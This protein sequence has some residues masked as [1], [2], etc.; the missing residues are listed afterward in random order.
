MP[1]VKTVVEPITFKR[2]D[3]WPPVAFQLKDE[4]N[5]TIPLAG[6]KIL[7]QVKKKATDAVV[8]QAF[9]DESGFIVENDVAT[10]DSINA[11]NDLLVGKYVY[12]VQWQLVNGIVRTTHEGPIT[13]TQDTSR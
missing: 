7:M 9:T 5:A 1:I 2:G 11:P 13:I 4:N 10:I 8:L 6:V 12:D 3:S